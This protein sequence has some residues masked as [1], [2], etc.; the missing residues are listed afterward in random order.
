M[1]LAN[2]ASQQI[3]DMKHTD[4]GER[5]LMGRTDSFDHGNS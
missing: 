1:Q 2:T 5:L 4:S 3:E